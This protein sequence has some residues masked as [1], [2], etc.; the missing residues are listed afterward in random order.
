MEADIEARISQAQSGGEEIVRSY[1]ISKVISQISTQFINLRPSQ[2]EK[3]I[4]LALG[5]FWTAIDVQR[6]SILMLDSDNDTCRLVNKRNASEVAPPP[7]ALHKISLSDFSWLSEQIFNGVPCLVT[8]GETDLPKHAKS[9][10]IMFR[11]LECFSA[12][13]IPMSVGG[14]VIGLVGFATMDRPY[15]WPEFLVSDLVIAGQIFANALSRRD[16]GIEFRKL[17]QDGLTGEERERTRISREVHDQLGGALTGL[18][19][20]S[21]ALHQQ[22]ADSGQYL[23]RWDAFRWDSLFKIRAGQ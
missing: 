5:R 23:C 11:N 8:D 4:P 20:H 22:L 13:V 18:R 6:A 1:G 2:F 16:Q 14:K 7:E 12:A 19:I 10:L 21:R 15:E 9:E 17:R 3:E